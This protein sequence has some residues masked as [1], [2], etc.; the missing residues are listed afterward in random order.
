VDEIIL[1]GVMQN[2]TPFLIFKMTGSFS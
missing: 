2:I 1:K